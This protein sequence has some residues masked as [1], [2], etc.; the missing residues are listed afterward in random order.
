MSDVP[1][2]LQIREPSNYSLERT[3]DGAGIESEVV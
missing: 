2:Y 3:R 1:K